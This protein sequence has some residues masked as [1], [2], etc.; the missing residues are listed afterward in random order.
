MTNNAE[1]KDINGYVRVTV[2]GKVFT[3][4]YDQWDKARIRAQHKGLGEPLMTKEFMQKF[5][6]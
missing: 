4:T 6:G 3:F 5:V 1:V 2:F